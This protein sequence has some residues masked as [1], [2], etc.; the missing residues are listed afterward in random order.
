MESSSRQAVQQ[1]LARPAMAQS[2][3]RQHLMAWALTLER[4][5]LKAT[6]VRMQLSA[7]SSIAAAPVA[8][9]PAESGSRQVVPSTAVQA[10]SSLPAPSS[11]REG[12][13]ET[14]RDRLQ[15]SDA[16]AEAAYRQPSGSPRSF[17]MTNSIPFV[18]TPS[19]QEFASQ[20]SVNAKEFKD[21]RLGERP[22][23]PKGNDG[24]P[25]RDTPNIAAT[26]P[27]PAFFACPP[28]LATASGDIAAPEGV[29]D[30]A[31]PSGEPMLMPIWNAPDDGAHVHVE[32]SDQGLSLWIRNARVSPEAA[33]V[34]A[35]SVVRELN[36]ERMAV[37]KVF[38]NGKLLIDG[39]G[40][41]ELVCY[42]NGGTVGKRAVLAV[43]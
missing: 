42:V 32:R 29:A 21:G 8:R 9:L 4:E 34:F 35:K 39:S 43:A 30:S 18:Q 27:P 15:S 26:A 3:G 31:G 20:L 5:F 37:A 19:P 22:Q 1:S 33:L 41:D 38:V 23:L 28:P 17:T 16:Q 2:G 14:S 12:A 7:I 36:D 40:S 24:M 25:F 13:V 6:G 10:N 11:A